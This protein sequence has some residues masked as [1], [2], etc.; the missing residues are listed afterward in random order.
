MAAGTWGPLRSTIPALTMPSWSSFLTGKNP[1]GHGVFAFT[2]TDPHGYDPGG[3]AN[4]GTVRSPTLWDHIGRGGGTVGAVNVPPAYPL[5]PVNGYVVGC[6]LTP[7][8]EPLIEPRSLAPL[9]A[10][11]VVDLKAPRRLRAD[12]RT[13]AERS[14]TY[15]AALV[16]MTRRRT[17]ATLRLAAARPTDVLCVVFYSPDRVQHNFWDELTGREVGNPDVVAVIAHVYRALDE[18]IG[19]LVDQAGPDA[20]VVL[21]SDHGFVPRPRRSVRVNRW[22]ADAGFVAEHPH[23]RLRRSIVRRLPEPLRRRWDTLDHLQ[24]RRAGTRAWAETLDYATAGIWIHVRGRYPLGLVEPGREY[25]ATRARIVDGLLALRG[26][27][28]GRVFREVHRRES[29]YSGPYVDE[30]PDVVAVCA[31]EFGVVNQSLRRD[32]RSRELFGPFDE[33]GFTGTHDPAGIYLF[34]GANVPA[35][36]VHPELPIQAIAPTVLYLLGLPVPRSMDGPVALDVLD[37][38]LVGGRAVAFVDDAEEGMAG[39]PGWASA[40]DEARVAE[41]L[42]SLG[43]ME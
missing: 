43:Y 37:P 10:D 34:A 27:D 31:P 1:G 26:P 9:L 40:D 33:A 20:T 38:M 30:A 42:R 4:A 11:Y 22:L 29:L 13:F 24:V 32:L 28:G 35:R 17:D 41:H 23:W 36:T 12:M 14:T 6:L 19:R 8:G 18:A 3:I 16:D 39:G 25:E 5:R 2:R 7:P 21:V 15:L